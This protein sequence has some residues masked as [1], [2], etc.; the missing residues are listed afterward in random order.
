M[1]ANWSRRVLLSL[2]CAT[3]GLLAACGSSTIESALTP[4][5]FLAVG[6]AFSDLGQGGSRY[7]VNDGSV[8]IWSEQLAS[9][10]GL[11]LSASNSGG[12]SYAQA[13]ARVSSATDAVGGSAASITAQV[14]ALLAANSFG[15]NDVV[16]VQGGIGD[17]IAQMAS[18]GT[19]NATK[20][21]N[22]NQAG[23]EL[24]AQARRLV[25]AGAKYVIVVGSYNLGQS[26]WAIETGQRDLLRTLSTEFNNGLLVAINDLGANVLYV[27]AA[28]YFN[29]V[30]ATPG[31]YG[32]TD[33][34]N[35]PDRNPAITAAEAAVEACAG[36]SI[37]AGVG[38]GTGTGEANSSLCTSSTI[39]SG[40]NY[41]TTLFADRVYMTPA[42]QRLFG[43]YA[44][45]KLRARW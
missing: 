6:D 36:A 11:T 1:I 44:Y 10:F 21:A 22:L 35:S 16:L 24:G 32:L 13:H 29:L 9:R 34:A 3:A 28:L 40:V 39:A 23:R 15:A 38:I 18:T 7:T 20:A 2:A 31:G 45:D 42:G 33:P 17:I 8:N 19:D 25:T 14:D 4:S 43:N 5:R 30:T 12:R 27:D 37:D 41:N 26:R